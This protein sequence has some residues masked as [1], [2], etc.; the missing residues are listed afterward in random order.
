[1]AGMIAMGSVLAYAA[2][3]A[4]QTTPSSTPNVG[5][6]GFKDD[7][8]PNPDSNN[9]NPIFKTEDIGTTKIPGVP[10]KKGTPAFSFDIGWV[11]NNG[12]YYLADRTNKGIDIINNV[13]NNNTL[14]GTIGGFV[15]FA[16]NNDTAGPNGVV[17]DAQ[18]NV[19]W[20]G[21]GDSTLKAFD[22]NTMQVTATVS[23]GGKKR[24]D[25]L[26]YDPGDN[27]VLI[28]N[29]A[30]DPPF[31]TFVS[32]TTNKVVGQI[33]YPDA[34][35]GI[36]Q[37]VYNGADGAFYVAIPQTTANPGG[38]IDR[39]DPKALAISA[40]LAVQ[41]CVPHG[42]AL[43]LNNQLLLG[44]SGDGMKLSG[45]AQTQMMDAATGKIVGSTD[46]VGGSDEV[47]YLPGQNRY[48]LAASSMTA[49]GTPDGKP[50]P[51]MGV[52]DAVTNTWIENVP[53]D[54]GSHS[55]A[56]DPLSYQVY[57]PERSVGVEWFL[58]PPPLNATV[59]IT[60]QGFVPKVVN[61]AQGSGAN[62]G[63]VTFIN[64]G[65]KAHTVTED[66]SISPGFKVSAAGGV[67]VGG[68]WNGVGSQGSNMDTGGIGAGQSQ[69]VGFSG[70]DADYAYTSFT[71]CLAG[72]KPPVTSFDC[73]STYVVHVT[74]YQGDQSLAR[75]EPGTFVA[76]QGTEQ[77]KPD[78]CVQ[79]RSQQTV[80]ASGQLTGTQ[81][82][83]ILGYR[84][85]GKGVGS[86][87]KP[88]TGNLDVTID[89]FNGFTPAKPEIT[90]GTTVTWTNKGNQIHSIFYKPAVWANQ[91]SNGGN[92]VDSGGLLPGQTFSY[93][94]PIPLTSSASI[95]SAIRNDAIEPN[96]TPNEQ[97]SK[98]AS[99]QVCKGK[100][101]SKL[102]AAKFSLPS[103]YAQT[104][105]VVCG[106]AAFVPFGASQ[107]V[108]R[109]QPCAPTVP[110]LSTGSY[111]GATK[112]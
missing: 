97:G 47:W 7:A 35:N 10:A 54:V 20:A 77:T 96:M 22:I 73:K 104:V 60:D 65:S 14:R 74:D 93:T 51:V 61:V 102:I 99:A 58:S 34:T 52:I 57:V 18:G 88:L 108:G 5:N 106:P 11:D 43:G 41:N 85:R 71:D 4:A 56:A 111:L 36:E 92:V 42:L 21:D 109:G 25:E 101:C 30:D 40:R 50:T 23:T 55:V 87:Q 69:T 95:I 98:Q 49:D 59:Y 76:P 38:E 12:T 90:A 1:M 79:V 33:K 112:A 31:V 64:K 83:C 2:P 107:G 82:L 27:L 29:D 13:Y 39:I 86:D 28:A 37:P 19:G 26:A 45:H 24:A 81:N 110:T 91:T 3:A 53:T 48:Y 16:G 44:C 17:T 105:K 75:T 89:D 6:T 80:D 63:V 32:T 67:S 68:D 72:D 94:F 84:I 103:L 15:G 70:V 62:A 9:P 66:K 8:I 78:Q 100:N 46:K